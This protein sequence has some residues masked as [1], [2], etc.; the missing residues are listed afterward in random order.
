MRQGF[1]L[2]TL[3]VLL[4]TL[5]R[6]QGA[7]TDAQT[8]AILPKLEIIAGDVAYCRIGS[9]ADGVADKTHTAYTLMLA[10]AT[11]RLDGV[12][13]DLRF[14]D[15]NDFAAAAA[16]AD[17]FTSREHPLLDFGKG[18]VNSKTK[19]DAITGPLVILVNSETRG[20]AEALAAALHQ[21]DSG[22]LI[23]NAT[24]GPTNAITVKLGDGTDLKRIEPDIP[25]AV[26]LM[27]ER[28]RFDNPYM[29]ALK[30]E[31]STN[32]VAVTNRSWGAIER[33][34]E[35]DLVR[36]R[37]NGEDINNLEDDDI[38]PIRST[39]P[40]PPTIRDP[41]LARAVDFIKGVAALHL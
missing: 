4:A 33:I 23:G 35:A 20:A 19:S 36:A 27:D 3:T 1:W 34:S 8:N 37:K 7:L 15:G 16:T 21:T 32:N 41:A 13:L 25:V 10:S 26:S 6:T 29:V 39:E 28:E 24:A 9:V 18:I 17:L 31:L 11:N 2:V 14:A 40:E 5:A 38:T 30:S 22:L 12:V